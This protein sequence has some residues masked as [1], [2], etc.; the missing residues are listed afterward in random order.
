M[1]GK[2]R[3][4]VP[5]RAH[6]KGDGHAVGA[7]VQQRNVNASSGGGAG[8]KGPAAQRLA[9]DTPA[10]RPP[11]LHVAGRPVIHVAR[12]DSPDDLIDETMNFVSC[13]SRHRAT[14][15][16]MMLEACRLKYG[17]DAFRAIARKSRLDGISLVWV[18][19]SPNADPQ[20]AAELNAR[21]EEEANEKIE[22]A[23]AEDGP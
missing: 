23:L 2:Q 22:K 10:T 16:K 19:L 18:E 21:L 14:V 6:V 20:F 1:G 9:G 3:K 12:T 7:Y 13:D 15:K 17:V 5:V 8:V 11:V 4:D